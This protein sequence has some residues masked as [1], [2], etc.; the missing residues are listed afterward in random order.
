MQFIYCI[1]H[2]IV[3]LMQHI[4][5]SLAFAVICRVHMTWLSSVSIV[6]LW[7]QI[8]EV[9][10]SIRKRK[11]NKSHILKMPITIQNMWAHNCNLNKT[12]C[13]HSMLD[14]VTAWLL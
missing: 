9:S 5:M 4:V 13:I 11:Y 12:L 1:T 6:L 8:V 7:L 2:S 14:T 10:D 3:F